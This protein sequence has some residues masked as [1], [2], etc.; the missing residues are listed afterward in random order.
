MG[1]ALA[2]NLANQ[3]NSVAVFNRTTTTMQDFIQEYGTKQLVGYE[4]LG[5]L[6]QNLEKPRKIILMIKSGPALDV[7]IE[8][9]EQLLEA[10]DVIIDGGNSAFHDTVRRQKD[11]QLKG[12]NYVGLGVSGG[13]EG[14]LHG[15]SLMFG[16]TEE[17]WTWLQPHL[18]SIAAKDFQEKPC[19]ARL[20]PDGAGH[21]IKMVHN[22]IEYAM[23]QAIS[24]IYDLLRKVYDLPANEIEQVFA[25]LN[26]D[27]LKSFLLDIT[28]P[29][30]NQKD[31]LGD[32]YLVD[33]ILDQ[34]AQKG[35]GLWTA[36]DS[37]EKGI[38]ADTLTTAVFSRYLSTQR[39]LRLELGKIFET[40][41]RTDVSDLANLKPQLRSALTLSFIVAFTQ[42]FQLIQAASKEHNWH[43]DLAQVSRVWQGGCIIRIRL[44]DTIHQIYQQNPALESLLLSPKLQKNL[45]DTLAGTQT[46]LKLG[47]EKGVPLPAIS[48]SLNYFYSLTSPKL[49]ANLIQGLRDNFGAHTYKRV[50]REGDFHTN[51]L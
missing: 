1:S 26:T 24:E 50:D 5:E 14:A 40:S 31:D 35:T 27:D 37:L 33:Q 30:L 36:V 6:V 8:V 48:S 45:Q 49:P 29:V 4:T 9:L 43:I 22:G 13:E 19:V 10:E 38:P 44:L 25:E 32:G 46:I 20:G 3:G 2:R 28:T 16:G 51:W 18:E 7:Q 42:G 47:L 34:A 23:M 17:T 11:L 39:S 21:Y 12:L 15:P 41:W